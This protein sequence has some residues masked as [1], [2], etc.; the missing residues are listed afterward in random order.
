MKQ[1]EKI[2]DW[3]EGKATEEDVKNTEGFEA[4]KKI[5]L[6]TSGLEVPKPNYEKLY[7]RIE[8]S[9]NNSFMSRNWLK[10]AASV[11]LFIGLSSGIYF[12]SHN[13]FITQNQI[14]EVSL[15]DHSLVQ[16]AP[17]SKLSFNSITWWL[18]KRVSLAGKAYF[19][20][21]KGSLFSVNTKKAMIQVLG[22][23][24]EINATEEQ[25][26]VQCFEGKVS[27]VEL[28]TGKKEILLE[29]EF[30]N[31]SNN[32]NLKKGNIPFNLP[33]WLEKDIKLKEVEF[34]AVVDLL[35]QVFKVEIDASKVKTN[36]EF[37][38]I[39]STL[40]LNENFETLK[41]TYGIKISKLNENMYI[42]VEDEME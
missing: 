41:A 31:K 11:M 26:L 3:F 13:T 7:L 24:F 10:I 22:T 12:L 17:N 35:K 16:L 2:L 38:G 40:D 42:F 1:N 33:L 28:T 36:K 23:K 39:L 29:S 15:P 37:S 19:E 21:E 8:K 20:V 30:I 9:K 5:Q 6:Y 25:L 27:V 4:Y 14:V 18:D 32:T 34:K